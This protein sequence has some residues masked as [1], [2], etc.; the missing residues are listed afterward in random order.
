MQ[1]IFLVAFLSLNFM[2]TYCQQDKIVEDELLLTLDEKN[3]L[4]KVILLL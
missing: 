2:S 4:G 1:L 3:A